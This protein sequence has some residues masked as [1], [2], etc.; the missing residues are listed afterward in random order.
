MFA[1]QNAVRCVALLL[2]VPLLLFG[3][4]CSGLQ[5]FSRDQYRELTNVEYPDHS[6]EEVREAARE[7]LARSDDRMKFSSSENQ[8]RAVR[9]WKIITPVAVSGTDQWTLTFQSHNGGTRAHLK[10]TTLLTYLLGGKEGPRHQ[11]I[12]PDGPAVYELFWSRVSSVLNREGA[13]LSCERMKHR[14]ER[15]KT[16]GHLNLLCGKP[17]YDYVEEYFSGNTPP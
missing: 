5:T 16:F 4:G 2:T 1:G 15:G 6:P 8:L 11:T 9:W 12:S 17:Y 3:P 7:V 13:W 14:I 10:V